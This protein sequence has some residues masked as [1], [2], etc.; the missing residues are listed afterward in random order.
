MGARN[1]VSIPKQET[2]THTISLWLTTSVN[3]TELSSTP[4]SFEASWSNED[5]E[6]PLIWLG[7][8]NPTIIKYEDAIIPYMVF[9]P[10]AE[11]V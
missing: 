11:E 7:E 9:D 4:I 8:I 2:G 10:K 3:N 6:L 1:T 5:N